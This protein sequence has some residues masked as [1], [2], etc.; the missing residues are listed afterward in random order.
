LVASK[1]QSHAEDARSRLAWLH[2]RGHCRPD[3]EHA[4]AGRPGGKLA[5]ARDAARRR[6]HAGEIAVGSVRL[7]TSPA[8]TRPAAISNTMEWTWS[9]PS[10]REPAQAAGGG[11]D[12]RGVAPA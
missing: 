9:Q 2:P 12:C 6:D 1:P 7:F 3:D 4:D 11:D 8:S 5:Q 10:L